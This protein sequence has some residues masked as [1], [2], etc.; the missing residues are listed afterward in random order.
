MYSAESRLFRIRMSENVSCWMTRKSQNIFKFSKTSS[1]GFVQ[2]KFSR[3]LTFENLYQRESFVLDDSRK[4]EHYRS[5]I[6]PAVDCIS[7]SDVSYI[8]IMLMYT[9]TYIYVYIYIYIYLYIYIY[10]YIHIYMHTYFE[11][12]YKYIYVYM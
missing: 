9:Y 4:L 3:R 12:I 8:A 1:V 11:H 7:R 10:T 5:S 6:F 2:G